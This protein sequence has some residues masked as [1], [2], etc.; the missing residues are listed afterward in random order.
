MNIVV[1]ETKD[2]MGQQAA[3]DG[4]AFIR[5]ALES[6]DVANIILATGASQFEMLSHL[7]KEENIDW[8]R[9]NCFHLDEY[10]GMSIEHPASFRKYLK[11]RFVDELPTPPRS[12]HYINAEADL[13]EECRRLGAEISQV[14]ID[15]AFIGIGENAHLAFNDP[16]AD[17]ET[18]ESYI[19]VDLDEACRQQQHG[20][21]WFPTLEDVPKQ[22]ISMSIQHILK[23]KAII[24]T[25]PDERKAKAV[26]AAVEGEK[27]PDSPATILQEHS[28]TT[29]YLDKPAASLLN[30]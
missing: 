9:V 20:E 21:G 28:N 29:L 23:S 24:C 1:H 25:V 17:F 15:V 12:F 26:Q 10:A 11:E 4:A 19:V 16:P 8:G 3:S 22:A 30:A 5:K 2:E 18:T 13:A 6:Q 14:E 7:V 27:S